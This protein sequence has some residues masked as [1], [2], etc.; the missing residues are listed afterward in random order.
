MALRI[1]SFWRGGSRRLPTAK[2]LVIAKNEYRI[3]TSSFRTLRRVFPYFIIALLIVYV[4]FIAPSV[5]N[6]FIDDVLTFFIGQAAI[7][8]VQ[9]MLLMIFF[10]F[11]IIRISNTLKEVQTEQLEVFHAAPI[12]PS[13][14]LLGEFLGVMPFYAIVVV[15]ISGTFTALMTPLGFSFIQTAV[16]ITVFALTF[17]S[18]LWIGTVTAA[19]LRTRFGK[20]ARG[21]DIGRALALL[22]ALP[23]I[24]VMYAIMGGG[25]IQA[26]T[27]PG[28]SDLVRSLLAILPSSWGAEIFAGFVSHP[29]NIMA[30]GLETMTRFSG[31]I[32][33]FIALLWLGVK[34]ADRA[35]SLETTA[36]AAS[37]AKADGL[38]C[39]TVKRVGGGGSFGALLVSVFKDYGRRLENLSK[40]FYMLGLLVIINVLLIQPSDPEGA[41]VITQFILPLLS[42]F[43]VGEV[44]LR[45]KDALFIYKKA[46][47][48]IGRLIKAR[49]IKG[50]LIVVPI[51]GMV[52]AITSALNPET[53]LTFL[54]IEAGL[55][56]LTVVSNVAFVLGLFLLNPAFSDKSGNYVVNIMV[57]MQLLPL[58]T[59]LLPL[60]ILGRAF[61]LGLFDILFLVTVP[62]S[63]LFGITALYL[64]KRRMQRIE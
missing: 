63:W 54:L 13:D 42:A 53:T 29:G 31:L 37:R 49:L 22:I 39:K 46:P 24:G 36:F 59:F 52:T 51:S 10:Y 58:G 44:T 12:K 55:V 62:M 25:L 26:L 6:L 32:I 16:V 43:V 21:K 9:I 47:S 28:T 60:F 5:A 56:T 18:A 27:D 48:G 30:A 61:Q 41:L 45:G 14:V 38:F 23:L 2:W 7:P 64:G 19:A 15:I 11:I 1:G 4:G 20:T 34:I 8:M 33:F 35:Y 57:T 17:F 50:L 40:I 3:R